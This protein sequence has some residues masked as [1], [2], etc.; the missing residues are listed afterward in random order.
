MIFQGQDDSI[1]D[2]QGYRY[3]V[4]I[5][6]LNNSNQVFWAKRLKQDAW[7]FPQGGMKAGEDIFDCL[8]RELFEEVGLNNEQVE[9]LAQTKKWLSY[10]LPMR[11]R[12]RKKT[13]FIQCVGQKQRWFLLRL[14][15]TDNEIN[16]SAT[17][18][19]EFDD[20]QWIDYW[21]PAQEVVHFKRE[22][23]QAALK[24]FEPLIFKEE[25]LVSNS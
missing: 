23:Y 25:K 10:K 20:W 22:V 2:Q 9:V 16:L 13:S 4:G 15:A 6:L 14:K 5:V 21:R 3:N 11:Y 19:P 17:A 8:F 12:R 18:H 24:E 1:F 7:Q